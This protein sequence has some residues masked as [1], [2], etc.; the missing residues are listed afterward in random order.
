MYAPT[1]AHCK[2]KTVSPRAIIDKDSK[3]DIVDENGPVKGPFEASNRASS[4]AKRKAPL[5]RV[6]ARR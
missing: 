5:G 4:L 1:Y 2:Y 3:P 6:A